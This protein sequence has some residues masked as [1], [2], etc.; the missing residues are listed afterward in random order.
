MKV[1]Q[2]TSEYKAQEKKKKSWSETWR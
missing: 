1:L 2:E